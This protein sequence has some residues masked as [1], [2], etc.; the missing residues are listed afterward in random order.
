MKCICSAP[1]DFNMNRPLADRFMIEIGRWPR[2]VAPLAGH[3]E[4]FRRKIEMR[5]L[6]RYDEI[7][8]D[9]SLGDSICGK[10]ND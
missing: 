6:N 4:V 5:V 3:I 10:A 7:Y 9:L 1:V 2:G 8:S